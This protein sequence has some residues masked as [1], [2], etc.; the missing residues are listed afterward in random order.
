[1]HSRCGACADAERVRMRSGEYELGLTNGLTTRRE[2]VVT[3]LCSNRVGTLAMKFPGQELYLSFTL[4]KDYLDWEMPGRMKVYLIKYKHMKKE[5]GNHFLELLRT[6]YISQKFVLVF[7][8]RR[9]R[10]IFQSKS[11]NSLEYFENKCA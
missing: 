10:I 11:W 4:Q 3:H 2:I 9:Q 8:S 6:K 5:G 7:K 1:M